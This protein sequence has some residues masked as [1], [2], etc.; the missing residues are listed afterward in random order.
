MLRALAAEALLRIHSHSQFWRETEPQ[1]V[2]REEAAAT[3]PVRNVTNSGEGLEE[4]LEL[5]RLLAAAL[6]HVS[7][8]FVRDMEVSFS[9]SL[10]LALSLSLSLS[11]A[12]CV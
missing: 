4:S 1:V 9:L 2:A 6:P 12:L 11:L 10:S 5:A 3:G 7:A 8:Q